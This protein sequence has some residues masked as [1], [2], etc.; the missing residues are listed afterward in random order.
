[1]FAVASSQWSE[2]MWKSDA[3]RIA[4]ANI[5]HVRISEFD[6]AILEPRDGYFNWTLLDKSIEVLSSHGLKIIL[7]TPTAAPPLWATTKYDILAVD[8]HLYTRRFGSRR[9][10]SFSSPDFQKLSKRIVSKMARRYGRHPSIAAWQLDNEFGNSASARSYDEN[11]EKSFQRWL[12][13]KYRSIKE[14]NIKQGRV[15][16]SSQYTSFDDVT[17][18]HL[19]M[20]E[21][22]PALRLDYYHFSSDELINFATSQVEIIRK[23]SGKPITTNFMAFEFSFDH[24][25]FAR[26]TKIDF[27][28][29]D[30]YPL[31]NTEML[32]WV[33]DAEK[34]L[35]ARTGRPDFQALQHAFMRGL[36][37]SAKYKSSGAWGVMEQQPGPVNWAFY[38]PSPAPGQVRLWLH[39][40]I[41]QGSSLNNIFR[42]RQ[43][44]F[45]QEQMHAG[46]LRHDDHF[47]VAYY[48]QQEAVKDMNAL[49]EAG[50]STERLDHYQPRVAI[51]VDYASAWFLQANPQ[52]GRYSNPSFQDY[53]FQYAEVLSTWHSALRKLAID[54]DLI[55]PFVDPSNYSLLLVPTMINIGPEFN[56]IL[57]KYQGEV[58]FGARTASKVETLSQPPG[59]SPAEGALR[60]RLPMKITRV[61]SIRSRMADR[62]RYQGKLYNVSVWSEWLECERGGRKASQESEALF[63]TYRDGEPAMCEHVEDGKKTTYLGWYA[64]ETFLMAFFA[65]HA[66][67]LGVKTILGNDPDVQRHLGDHVRLARQGDALFAFNYN[68][69]EE[70]HSQQLPEEALLI[71]GGIE[72]NKSR[73]AKSGV[74]IYKLAS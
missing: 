44:P 37:G 38:N 33:S 45:G 32:P 58:I 66:A 19:E 30:S 56:D 51:V 54:V 47:D 61:E 14:L 1:M 25:E 21:S 68:D 50:V 9:H 20:E 15:F 34:L 36:A 49:I 26:R 6:W 11:A 69:R 71:I 55:A 2:T 31:G 18:P 73:I 46:M 40:M 67:E 10:Y 8:D 59:L 5:S 39:D 53:P 7:G 24:Y 29:W 72:G 23:H 22:S 48:E 12:K 52:G 62:V 74:N 57:A 43:V 28:T 64:G 17:I 3:S 16:W 42:W 35:Y 41:S 27:T 60:N 13:A 65:S 70:G 4:A 63:D